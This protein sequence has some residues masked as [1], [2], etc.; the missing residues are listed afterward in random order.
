MRRIACAYLHRLK[1]QLIFESF[2]DYGSTLH[3]LLPLVTGEM[4]VERYSLQ[5]CDLLTGLIPAER[6]SPM[7]LQRLAVFSIMWSMGALL[8][9]DDRAKMESFMVKHESRLNYPKL[10]GDETIFEYFV[11]DNGK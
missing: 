3:T 5:A 2:Y 11:G 7:H 1:V 9:L 4:I 10:K 8:E 6:V